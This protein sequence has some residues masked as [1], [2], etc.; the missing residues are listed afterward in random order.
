MN[1]M[2]GMCGMSGMNGSQWPPRVRAAV[3]H[4][5]IAR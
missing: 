3:S 2:N 4:L 5:E 1:G